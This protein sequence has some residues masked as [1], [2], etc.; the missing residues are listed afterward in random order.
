MVTTIQISD[1][2]WE[3]ISNQILRQ[4]KLLKRKRITHN[5]IIKGYQDLNKN[6]SLQKELDSV[7][8]AR[9]YINQSNPQKVEG[10]KA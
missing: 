8:D 3:T 5:D 7:I 9:F 1:K 10:A 2:V 4:Q 6:L